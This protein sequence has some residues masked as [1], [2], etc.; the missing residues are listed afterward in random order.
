[1]RNIVRALAAIALAAASPGW[2]AEP[3]RVGLVDEITGTQAEAGQLTMF[4]AKLA[5]EEIN[6]AG[7][8]LGRRIELIVEDNQSTNPGTVLAYSKLLDEGVVAVL[9]PLRSTQVQAASPTIARGRIPAIIGGSDPSLTRVNNPWIFRVRPNDLYSSKVMAEYG[10]N[11]LGRKKWAI[12]HSTDTFGVG[13]KNALAEALKKLG[14]EPVLVQGYTNNSQDFAP[15]VLAIKGSGA[16]I[17]GSYMTNSPDVGI[18]ARQLKQ[19]GVN[20]AWIGSTSLTTTTA[21]NL[22]G[23]A[24]W[25]TYSVSDFV[26][27]GNPES[28]AFAAKFR[29]KHGFDPDLYSAWSYGGMYLL[30]HAAEKAGSTEADKVRA[31]MLSIRGLKGVEG[32]YDFDPNGDG[33]HG[34]NVVKN[35]KGKIVFIERIDFA[36]EGR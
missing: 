19:L 21:M 32:T 17:I 12:L 24:L 16:D 6:A 23:D 22:A 1:M 9:G 2:A 5:Q 13:G 7:G 18:F 36:P 8:I 27:D 28:K 30:K 35:E 20:V 14:V 15:I 26:I 34:Y 31:A 10:V 33:V 4:G 11:K 29:S 3:I 25:G